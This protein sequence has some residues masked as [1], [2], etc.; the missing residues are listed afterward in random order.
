[1]FQLSKINGSVE[2]AAGAFSLLPTSNFRDTEK[3]SKMRENQNNTKNSIIMVKS[4]A[5]S[6]SAIYFTIE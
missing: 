3:C 2:N 5:N 4:I 1:M 6:N